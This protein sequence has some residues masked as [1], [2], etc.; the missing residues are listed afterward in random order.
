MK[1]TTLR[2]NHHQIS[3][4]VDKQDTSFEQEDSSLLE[5]LEH[6]AWHSVENVESEKDRF[7]RLFRHEREKRKLISLRIPTDTLHI[8]RE[9]AK[10]EGIPYQT[11]IIS[12][13]HKYN[14]GSHLNK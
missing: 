13:I 8:F 7:N 10:N 12:L 9:K 1:T 11:L 5:S 14:Q 4:V 3:T 6:D 2:N